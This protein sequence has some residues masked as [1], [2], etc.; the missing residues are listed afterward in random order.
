MNRYKIEYTETLRDRRFS[1]DFHLKCNHY[2]IYSAIL[3]LKAQMNQLPGDT[4]A[5]Q[6]SLFTRRS[7]HVREML[8]RVDV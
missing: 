4:E 6:P 2:K 3:L 8:V 7:D 1:R 5:Y